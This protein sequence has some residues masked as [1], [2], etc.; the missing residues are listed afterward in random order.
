MP[1]AGVNAYSDLIKKENKKVWTSAKG[2]YRAVD[3]RGLRLI[4]SGWGGED[5]SNDK[6]TSLVKLH[7]KRKQRFIY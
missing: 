4:E 5:Q 6:M 7:L 3:E 1:M 2:Q